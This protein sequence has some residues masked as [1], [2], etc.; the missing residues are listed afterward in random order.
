[1][2]FLNGYKKLK[3]F[4]FNLQYEVDYLTL[5]QEKTDEQLFSLKQ[6]VKELKREL[7]ER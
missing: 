4:M 3:T 2:R 5:R 1:M 7:R 6:Q